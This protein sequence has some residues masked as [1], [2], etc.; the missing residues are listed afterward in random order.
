MLAHVPTSLLLAWLFETF[1]LIVLALTDGYDVARSGEVFRVVLTFVVL[2][3][4]FSLVHLLFADRRRLAFGVTFALFLVFIVVNVARVSTMGSFDYGFVR[5]HGPEILSPLGLRIVVT[6][7][8][9]G[10][11]AL[12]FLPPLVIAFALVKRPSPRWRLSRRAHAAAV[13]VCA[14]LLVFVV[15]VRIST[16]EALTTF[17]ASALRFHAEARTAESA[18]GED[19]FPHVH[20]FAPT[21][22]ARAIA[23]SDAPRPHIILLFLESHNGLFTDRLRPDGRRYTPVFDA[24]MAESLSVEHFYGN[25]V[26]SSRGHFATLC[27]LV[28]MYRGKEFTD[29]DATRFHCL[30]ETLADAGYDTLF[31]SATADP[32]FERS[33][34]FFHRIGFTGVTFQDELVSKEDPSFWGAGLQDDVFYKRFF[35]AVDEGLARSGG[36]PIFAVAANASNHYPFREGPSH[37]PDPDEPTKYRRDYVGSLSASDAWLA[38]FFDELDCRPALKD[39]IVVVVVSDHSFPADEHGIHFNMIGAYE[40]AFR[41]ALLL[42]WPGHVIPRVIRDRTASQ[43]DLAPTIADLLGLSGK[44]HFMGRSLFDDDGSVSASL[45]V[46]PYDGV[47]LVA[48]RWPFKLEVHESAEQEH[49]YDLSRDPAEEHDIAADPENAT[50]LATLRAE[51]DRIRANQ[52]LLQSGRIWPDPTL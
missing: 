47:H 29:L 14:A 31:Y 50:E 25:S 23:G 7:L 40:E 18:I 10:G 8:K 38:T 5:D 1:F 34:E 43:V 11:A 21:P 33:D 24:H 16:H 30:P 51:I 35:G 39:A 32:T 46:Q 27:S 42:R 3:A 4:I 9:I 12:L 26:H 28:P 6:E 17:A 41:A 22:A 48:V 37:E 13:T 19:A 15:T 52:V 20:D 44:T 2:T 36:K 49:L 45:M